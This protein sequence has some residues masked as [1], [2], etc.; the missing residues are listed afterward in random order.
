MSA[1]A[2]R[3]R[4]TRFL[5]P[6]GTQ[7][8]YP[9]QY[10]V[11]S[12]VVLSTIAHRSTMMTTP[13][14]RLLHPFTHDLDSGSGGWAAD[15]LHRSIRVSLLALAGGWQLLMTVVS[16]VSVVSVGASAWLLAIAHIGLALASFS[17]LRSGR[18][19]WLWPIPAAMAALGIAGFIVSGDL[20]SVLTFA[21]AWQLN[22]ASCA[23]GLLILSR[24]LVPAA[25]TGAV[26]M[27]VV[28]TLALPQWGVDFASF[29]FVTQL[30]IIAV[31]RIGLPLLL[32][33]ADQTDRAEAAARHAAHQAALT[34][35]V[36]L[37]VAEESRTLHDTAVNT[38][39]AIANGGAGA[40]DV[41][42]VRGQ[43]ANDVVM[44]E[45]LRGERAPLAATTAELTDLFQLPGLPIRRSG[46]D[47]DDLGRITA[48]LDDQLVTGML[49][50]AREAVTNA[51]RHSGGSS[52]TISTRADH[53]RFHIKVRDDGTGFDDTTVAIRGISSS[54]LGRAED[55]GFEA[56]VR[57]TVGAGTTVTL[58]CA[59]DEAP[60][61][62]SGVP[63]TY[64]DDVEAVVR[65]I[66]RRAGFAWAGGV[67][68]VSVVLT[69]TSGANYYSA[70]LPMLGLMVASWLAAWFLLHRAVRTSVF[71]GFLVTTLAVF[72]LSAA[73]TAFG[74]DGAVHW[75]ALAASGPLVL[76]MSYGVSRRAMITAVTSWGLTAA[77]LTLLVLPRSSV[78]AAITLVATCVSTA[79]WLIWSRFQTAVESLSTVTAAAQRR[80][81][82]ARLASD[83]ERVSQETYLRWLDAGLD[84]A[85]SLLR[86]ISEERKHP[87]HDDTIRACSQEEAYLRQLVLISPELVNL[88]RVSL[89]LL[90]TARERGVRLTLRLG[91]KD[92]PNASTADAIHDTVLRAV[93]ST[94][95]GAGVSASVYPTR[96]GLQLTVTSTRL[97]PE[98]VRSLPAGAATYPDHGTGPTTAAQIEYPDPVGADHVSYPSLVTRG[99]A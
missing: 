88:G 84:T 48:Q 32:A 79:F 23:A 29:A 33:L 50:A 70:L 96:G 82:L 27:F 18:R 83:A 97:D 59:L 9:R 47:D 51:T 72:V 39:G 15:A 86:A 46:L 49:G 3:P 10:L 94:P 99:A 73:A 66:H 65:E 25:I 63:R 93:N 57:S 12:T 19:Q 38:L 81:F 14:T 58:S 1:R 56:Q 76:L 64:V 42:Q 30:S 85:I 7:L 68:L 35:R 17:A 37:Q 40:S 95:E 28:L 26:A 11:L 34:H 98:F 43:C 13:V 53:H 69:L 61:Q 78:G 55:F 21:A 22:F 60:E 4:S 67:T 71:L 20:D 31:I 24:W 80:A 6:C 74:T 77:V 89:P 62:A 92:A 2:P 90:R 54:I 5:G 16:V 36:S 52:I 87:H 44:L 8:P 45:S 75:Q 91:D 41:G